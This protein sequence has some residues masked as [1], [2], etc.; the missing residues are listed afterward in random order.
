M[1]DQKTHLVSSGYRT[2]CGRHS[3]WVRSL[4][5]DELMGPGGTW[6]SA[7]AADR[8]TCRTCRTAAHI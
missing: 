8:I 7:E 1:P 5:V 6:I 3:N 2:Y 4:S